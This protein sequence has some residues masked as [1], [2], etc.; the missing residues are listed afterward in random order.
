MHNKANSV[1]CAKKLLG[2]NFAQRRHTGSFELCVLKYLTHHVVEVVGAACS[3]LEE[4]GIWF[5]ITIQQAIKN[6][7]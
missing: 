3:V 4:G 6:L 7:K 5:H 1:G 2:N